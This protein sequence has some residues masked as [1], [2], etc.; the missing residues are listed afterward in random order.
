MAESAARAR[1]ALSA[2]DGILE[3]S[4]IE[5]DV[6]NSRGIDAGGAVDGCLL[7]SATAGLSQGGEPGMQSLPVQR[8]MTLISCSS[9]KGLETWSFMPAA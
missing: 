4:W 2:V 1:A 6:T 9:S 3:R 8:P 5:R 7:I